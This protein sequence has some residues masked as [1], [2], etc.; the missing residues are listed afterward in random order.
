[1]QRNEIERFHSSFFY[2]FIFNLPKSLFYLINYLF[3]KYK[4]SKYT[5]NDI[6]VVIIVVTIVVIRVGVVTQ[7]VIKTLSKSRYATD[8]EIREIAKEVVSLL[9]KI[10]VTDGMTNIVEACLRYILNVSN[11]LPEEELQRIAGEITPEGS[12]LVMTVAEE[13]R[14][15]A[16]EIGI[17]E[18]L[19]KAAKTGIIKGH[20]INIIMDM[21]GLTEKE[22]EEIK[23]EMLK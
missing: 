20:D 16:L 6:I 4:L 5:R 22:I 3:L 1:M 7:I 18:G 23:Q 19:K 15:E 13:I 2:F 11:K 10:E 21:T 9:L 12:E 17:E 8:E 14:Q